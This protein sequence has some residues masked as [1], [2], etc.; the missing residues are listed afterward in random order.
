MF[1]APSCPSSGAYQLQKL[2]LIYRWN[3]VVAVLLVVYARI[4]DRRNVSDD[5]N[6][7]T[8]DVIMLNQI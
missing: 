2:P 8:P 7:H 1:R 6:F 4:Y 5:S 3:V